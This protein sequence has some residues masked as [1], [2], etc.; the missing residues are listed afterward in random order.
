MRERSRQC[1]L[2]YPARAM[3]SR[4]KRLSALYAVAILAM[5]VVAPGARAADA[6]NGRRIAEQRCA[7]CHIVSPFRRTEVA[8]APPFAVIARKYGFSA[9]ALNNAI[10]GP[11][12]KMN[13]SPPPLEAADLAAYM[14]TL[15]R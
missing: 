13:F 7:F 1:G 8:D 5:L 9:D 15:G 2:P 14:A 4:P 3:T 10:L 6:D 12:P 11:H